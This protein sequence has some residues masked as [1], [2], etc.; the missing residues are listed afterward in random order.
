MPESAVKGPLDE[1]TICV[2]CGFCCDGTLFLH[3]TLN[4][5][6]LGHLPQKI[7]QNRFTENGKEFF[8]LPC[9]YFSGKCIIYDRERA[10]ICS[11]YRCQLLRD[12]AGG[13]IN[14]YDAL[15]IVSE[16]MRM[17]TDLMDQYRR[18]SVNDKGIN[19]RQLLVDL[20]KILKSAPEEEPFRQDYE[21]LQTRCNIFEALLIKHIRSASDFQNIMITSPQDKN[22]PI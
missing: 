9:Y 10:N 16:A 2:T 18:I 20:G 15:E 7:E 19:F 3:A 8:R 14:L 5:N 22:N 17:R 1:Q 6:E 12:F 4:P 21:M 11:S 13:K